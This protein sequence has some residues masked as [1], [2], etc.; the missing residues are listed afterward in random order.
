MNGRI[1][2]VQYPAFGREM[3][4]AQEALSPTVF[5]VTQTCRSRRHQTA[6]NDISLSFFK[7]SCAAC[8]SLKVED[9]IVIRLNYYFY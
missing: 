5:S 7:E 4:I 1:R 8:S 2:C 6:R 3:E 9:G